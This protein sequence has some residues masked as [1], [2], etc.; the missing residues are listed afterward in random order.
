VPVRVSALRRVEPLGRVHRDLV[1]TVRVHLWRLP[2]STDQ[3]PLLSSFLFRL[4]S[5]LIPPS[6][7]H[8]P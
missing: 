2:T 6:T 5:S 4:S 3:R 8:P 7:F 1:E